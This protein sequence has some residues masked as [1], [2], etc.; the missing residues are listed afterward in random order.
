VSSKTPRSPR[1]APWVGQ[2][3]D[4]V[5]QEAGWSQTDIERLRVRGIIG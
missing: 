5:L 1:R 4:E 3:S 2:H